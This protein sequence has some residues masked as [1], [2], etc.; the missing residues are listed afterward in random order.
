MLGQGRGRCAVAQI[1][2]FMRCSRH[3][4]RS[5]VWIGKLMYSLRWLFSLRKLA[6]IKSLK[7]DVSS[8]SPS[9][10]RWHL[11]LADVGPSSIAL[12]KGERSKRQPLNSL[13][14]L[15]YVLNFV[16]NTKLPYYTLPQTQHRSFFRNLPPHSFYFDRL[17]WFN[18]LQLNDKFIGIKQVLV[19][20]IINK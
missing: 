9:S 8:V 7:A 15:I 12:T 17:T 1:L 16:V 6:A 20:F 5:V 4:L 10:E 2:I 19:Q 14:W 18:L 3:R 11:T 13:R